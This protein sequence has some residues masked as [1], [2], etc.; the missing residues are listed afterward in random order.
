M[1]KLENLRQCQIFDNNIAH[2]LLNKAFVKLL[3]SI[4]EESF[5][6]VITQ[7]C[8]IAHTNTDDEPF[9][10]FLL[11]NATTDRS[12]K[13][14]KSPRKLHLINNDKCL[15]FC[16]YNRFFVKK[17][18]IEDFDFLESNV[19]LSQDNKNI[20]KKWLGSRY[21]R[22]SFPDAFN[23]RMSKAFNIADKSISSKVSHIFF[24]VSDKEL[25]STES[26]KLNAL[27]V[28]DTDDEDLKNEIEK[29]YSDAFDVEG[30]D[31]YLSVVTESEVTLND[32]KQYKRWSHDSVSYS[33]QNQSLP[34]SEIDNII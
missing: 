22:A 15:E 2:E 9:I 33:K 14:G 32:I 29:K 18:D 5:C 6:I 8:D 4:T 24:H 26:Y 13:N 34:L 1:A 28:V 7:D 25:P 3:P 17:T 12:C 20:L 30:I 21:T 23:N 16:I 10:E 31:L 27:I 19:Q 11:G